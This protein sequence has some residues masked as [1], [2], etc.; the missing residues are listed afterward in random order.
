MK[1]ID[2]EMYIMQI[3]P[4]FMTSQEEVLNILLWLGDKKSSNLVLTKQDQLNIKQLCEVKSDISWESIIS[5][6]FECG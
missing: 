5:V 6:Y 2:V 3:E 4:W 1:K